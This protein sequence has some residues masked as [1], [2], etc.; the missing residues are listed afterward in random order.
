MQVYGDLIYY[1]YNYIESISGDNPTG[2]LHDTDKTIG[3]Q[4]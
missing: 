2:V 1:M 3:Q 4:Q